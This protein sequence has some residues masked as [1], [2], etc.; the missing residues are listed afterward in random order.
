M[1]RLKFAPLA[2]AAALIGVFVIN[3]PALGAPAVGV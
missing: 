3:G 1:F 2:L